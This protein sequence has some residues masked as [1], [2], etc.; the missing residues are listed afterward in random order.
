MKTEEEIIYNLIFQAE[1][2][3][4]ITQV[5]LEYR[6]SLRLYNQAAKIG[7]ELGATV[8]ANRVEFPG[9]GFVEFTHLH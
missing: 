8:G 4:K 6:E 7:L 5:S 9:K 1:A 3:H 2:G